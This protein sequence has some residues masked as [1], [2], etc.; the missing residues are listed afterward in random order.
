MDL[1]EDRYDLEW[2]RSVYLPF[3]IELV[4]QCKSYRDCI[5]HTMYN[6]SSDPYITEELLLSHR[7]F[8]NWSELS[9]TK[10]ITLD[11]IARHLDLPWDWSKVSSNPNLTMSFVLSYSIAAWIGLGIFLIEK[12]VFI[13]L[14]WKLVYQYRET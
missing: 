13:W 1:L 14:V 8:W 2:G 9:K 5:K 3:M 7:E 6:L 4:V 11:I 10:A 12:L